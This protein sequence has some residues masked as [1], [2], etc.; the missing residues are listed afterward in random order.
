M[1]K[2]LMLC[3]ILWE[4]TPFRVNPVRSRVMRVVESSI[5]SGRGFD[6]VAGQISS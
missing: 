5:K 3:S 1:V 4:K 6:R 2:E